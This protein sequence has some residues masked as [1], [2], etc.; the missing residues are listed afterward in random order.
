MADLFIPLLQ[1]VTHQVIAARWTVEEIE[2]YQRSQRLPGIGSVDKNF[3]TINGRKYSI[4]WMR[5]TA[6]GYVYTETLIR[7]RNTYGN[8]WIGMQQRDRVM[9]ETCAVAQEWLGLGGDG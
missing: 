3:V 5:V 1:E 2:L 6:G 4:I 9:Y 8:R 7:D